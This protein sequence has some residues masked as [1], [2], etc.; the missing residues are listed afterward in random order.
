[1]NVWHLGNHSLEKKTN[2]ITAIQNQYS[3]TVAILIFTLKSVLQI[4]HLM[5]AYLSMLQSAHGH[6]WPFQQPVLLFLKGTALLFLKQAISRTELFPPVILMIMSMIM[7]HS[8]VL[9]SFSIKVYV[10]Y[11]AL[12]PGLSMRPS[13]FNK[14]KSKNYN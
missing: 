3:A 14:Q 13:P 8:I 6:L 11:W 2:K 4:F 5:Y 1:M 7:M 10:Q 12:W 9:V